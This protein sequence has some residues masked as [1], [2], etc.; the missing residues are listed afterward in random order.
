MLH[1]VD[2]SKVLFLDIETVPEY[3]KFDDLSE[4]GKELWAK[5]TRVLTRT[6]RQNSSR[7]L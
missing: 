5:K 3:Y 2:F 1:N 7:N 4:R 6:R